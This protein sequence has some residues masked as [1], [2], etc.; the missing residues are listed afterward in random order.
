[1]KKYLT[2]G[3]IALLTININAQIKVYSG[4]YS[5]GYETGK[6]TY[7]YK[8]VDEDRIYQGFFKGT[9][10]YTSISGNYTNNKKNGLW[11]IIRQHNW[12]YNFGLETTTL[13]FKDGNLSGEYHYINTMSN[14]K[15]KQNLTKIDASYL[16]N[17]F[18]G[19]FHYNEK[20]YHLYKNPFK[21]LYVN[22][23]P[24]ITECIGQFDNNGYATG[25]WIFK[26]TDEKGLCETIYKIFNMGVLCNSYGIN[27]STGEKTTFY[28]D[29][30]KADRLFTN[31][32]NNKDSMKIERK[33]N[34][35]KDL[36]IRIRTGSGINDEIIEDIEIKELDKCWYSK[37]R[38]DQDMISRGQE[39]MKIYPTRQLLD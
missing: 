39:E 7:Q 21:G 8:E 20:V 19:Y 2:I 36:W 5:F 26:R 22:S 27:N 12:N 23:T 10:D 16:D 30:G 35:S 28:S 4:A 14:D 18:I 24:V 1:M 17:H 38:L 31:P 11:K 13:N 29:N 15:D 25:K 9:T 34:F 3:F 37:S 6:A 33:Y 32:N